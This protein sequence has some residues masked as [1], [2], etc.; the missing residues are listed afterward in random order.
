MA[1]FDSTALRIVLGQDI[2][3]INYK[4]LNE[5]IGN[6]NHHTDFIRDKVFY[7]PKCM[8]NGHHSIFHQLSFLNKCAFH[9]IKL[10]DKCPKCG[11]PMFY[12]IYFKAQNSP[13]ICS[14]GNFFEEKS[15]NNFLMKKWIEPLDLNINLSELKTFQEL[16]DEH[17]SLIN[18]V[19]FNTDLVNSHLDYFLYYM[20]SFVN[21]DYKLKNGMQHYMSILKYRVQN[22]CSKDNEVFRESF[23]A[24]LYRSIKYSYNSVARRLRNMLF[25]NK[26]CITNLK[27]LNFMYDDI[28][29]EICPLAFSYIT[30]R[31]K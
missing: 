30:W 23:A 12:K 21:K 8:E 28:E 3:T 1:G 5:I 16:K 10:L 14:C 13:N 26:S 24:D 18:R 7:C 15:K 17:K 20:L 19:Y 22:D 11:L 27:L 31:Q 25:K 4:N 2:K 29:E 6:I 9:K